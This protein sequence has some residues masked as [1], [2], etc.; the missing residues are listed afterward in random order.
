M[1][2]KI[3]EDIYQTRQETAS[4]NAEFT[5][6]TEGYECMYLNIIIIR[7]SVYNCLSC[8]SISTSRRNN[9]VC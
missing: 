7:A 1:I 3:K 9:N 8:S 6:I 4:L 2:Q 5:K